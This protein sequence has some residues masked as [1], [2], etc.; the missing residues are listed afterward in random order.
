MS[1]SGDKRT[2]HD[3]KQYRYFID[4]FYPCTFYPCFDIVLPQSI[5]YSAKL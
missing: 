2:K 4:T 3:T 1:N 5:T